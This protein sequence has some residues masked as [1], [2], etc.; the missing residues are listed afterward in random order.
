D[1]EERRR[2]DG[3]HPRVVPAPRGPVPAGPEQLLHVTSFSV[4]LLT[5][6]SPAAGRATGLYD[7]GEVRS[8][9]EVDVDRDGVAELDRGHP[10]SPVGALRGRVL[11]VVHAPPPRRLAAVV[12]VEDA[13]PDVGAVVERVATVADTGGEP[14]AVRVRG[15]ERVVVVLEAASAGVGA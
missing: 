9:G 6:Y 10:P 13:D 8:A 12:G 1:G 11:V 4:C 14:D 3:K 15:D 2:D 7:A 5:A